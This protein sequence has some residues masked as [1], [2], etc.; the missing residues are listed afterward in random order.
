MKFSVGYQL[1]EEFER[2]FFDIVCDYKERISEVYFPWLDNATGRG[3]LVDSFGYFDWSVQNKLVYDLK[4]IKELGIKLNLLYNGN[5]YGADA[6]SRN[7]SNRIY[8]IIDYLSVEGCGID[9]ITTASPAIAHMVKSKYGNIDVR[10]S[11]NMRIGT[12]KGMSYLAHLFDSYYIQRDYNRDFT[13]IKELKEWADKTIKGYTCSQTA[14]VCDFAH[15]R[16]F[17]TTWLRITAR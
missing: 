1:S 3:S 11:V 14:D 7:L 13:R 15:A 8:S 12:V 9:V 6:I 4:R 5:C 10:A 17:M 2:D 16:R